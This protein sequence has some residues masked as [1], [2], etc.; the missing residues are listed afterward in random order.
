M[1]PRRL[2]RE[3]ERLVGRPFRLHGRDLK[4]GV[5]CIGL[6]ALAMARGGCPV[7]VPT[8]YPLRLSDLDRWLPDAASCGFG[9][10]QLPY[11]PGDVVMLQAGPA[12]FHLAIAD[13][14]LGWIHAHA[15]LRRVV[16]DAE[17]PAGTLVHHW[18]LLRAR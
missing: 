4:G 12:Q 7:A 15:G 10:A 17:I 14:T 13:R 16:R 6:F 9:P 2:A 11:A 3:A 5:D 8:G 1:T 18:R